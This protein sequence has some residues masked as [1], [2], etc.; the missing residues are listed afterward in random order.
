MGK[1]YVD[2]LTTAKPELE[3]DDYGF[4]F[5]V[6]DGGKRFGHS[7]GFAGINS[8]LVVFRDE[9]YTI[10]VMSN[11]SMGAQPVVE[12]ARALLMAG[13]AATAAR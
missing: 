5:G 9:G 3:S 1:R 12:R 11:Y 8:E 13:R 4:G 2:I 10:A 7:G 6:R